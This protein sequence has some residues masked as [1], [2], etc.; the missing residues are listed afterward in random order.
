[1]SEGDRIAPLVELASRGRCEW[2]VDAQRRRKQEEGGATGRRVLISDHL[3]MPEETPTMR[4]AR[5]LASTDSVPGDQE[6]QSACGR[7]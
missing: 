6:V 1:M 5:H 2:Y 4:R 7:G 3:E